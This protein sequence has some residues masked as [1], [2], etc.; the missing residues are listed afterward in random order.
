M[1]NHTNRKAAYHIGQAFHIPRSAWK[2][3]SRFQPLAIN[4]AFTT[5]A[6]IVGNASLRVFSASCFG[7][8]GLGGFGGRSS[9]GA[10]WVVPDGDGAAGS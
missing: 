9:V 7:L 6:S 2:A 4:T 3:L 10:C 1:L 8:T 5:V